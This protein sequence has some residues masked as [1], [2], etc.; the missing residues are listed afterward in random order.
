MFVVTTSVVLHVQRPDF[1][2]SPSSN[3][4]PCRLLVANFC[5]LTTMVSGFYGED[6]D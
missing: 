6:N 2:R 5:G 3:K 1:S 4:Q